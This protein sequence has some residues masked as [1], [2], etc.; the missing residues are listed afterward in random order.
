M[1][2]A[3]VLVGA[4]WRHPV[5]RHV[6]DGRRAEE[7]R[8][9]H[10]DPRRVQVDP[11]ISRRQGGRHP[12][13]P[14]RRRVSESQ[15][16]ELRIVGDA[17]IHAIGAYHR[18]DTDVKEWYASGFCPALLDEEYLGGV[19]KDNENQQDSEAW[20]FLVALLPWFGHWA[21]ALVALDVR[22]DIVT[23]LAI[24]LRLRGS[25]PALSKIARDNSCA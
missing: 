14:L 6:E 23:A 18:T 9:A 19:P 13:A 20:N 2:L 21:Q 7:L 12:H 25:T 16:Q 8:P 17:S 3:P 11:R 15:R 24:V 5:R 1:R 22:A 4:L 10:A